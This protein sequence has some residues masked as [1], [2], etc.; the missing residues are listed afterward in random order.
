MSNS[1]KLTFYARKHLLCTYFLI[2]RLLQRYLSYALIVIYL[3][4]ISWHKNH[5]ANLVKSCSK[6]RWFY[7]KDRFYPNWLNTLSWKLH[8]ITFMLIAYDIFSHS[9]FPTFH[10]CISVIASL[11]FKNIYIA[12]YC[13]SGPWIYWWIKTIVPI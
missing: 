2:T 3:K 1:S 10:S 5:V 7:T 8:I 6:T 9:I 12:W 13:R 4:T 11:T